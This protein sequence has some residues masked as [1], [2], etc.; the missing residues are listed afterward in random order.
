MFYRPLVGESQE[1]ELRCHFLF[2]IYMF[3][4]CNMRLGYNGLL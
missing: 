1:E 3:S 2:A 4:Q